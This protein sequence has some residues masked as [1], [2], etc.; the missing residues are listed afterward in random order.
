MYSDYQNS[1]PGEEM[2]SMCEICVIYKC[3][4]YKYVIYM[5]EVLLLF[6]VLGAIGEWG[7]HMSGLF[8]L[9][10]GSGSVRGSSVVPCIK[11]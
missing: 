4:L 6:Y 8:L 9:N 7:V 5:S 10:S 1:K 11:S 3:D 2:H